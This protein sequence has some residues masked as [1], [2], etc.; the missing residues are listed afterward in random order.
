MI[1]RVDN[2]IYILSVEG[3]NYASYEIMSSYFTEFSKSLCDF[4][5]FVDS[6]IPKIGGRP[7]SNYRLAIFIF[8]FASF[9]LIDHIVRI[10]HFREREK[11]MVFESVIYLQCDRI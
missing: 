3:N 6:R 2:L 5:I 9:I 4:S 8:N 1:D 11:L 10:L 7:S